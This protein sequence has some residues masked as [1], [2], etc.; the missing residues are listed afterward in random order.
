[1]ALLVPDPNQSRANKIP[2][3]RTIVNSDP[4]EEPSPTRI[5]ESEKVHNAGLTPLVLG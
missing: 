5:R 4:A 3:I 2:L 1:M